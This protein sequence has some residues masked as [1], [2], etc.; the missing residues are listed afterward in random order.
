MPPLYQMAVW[1]SVSMAG[2]FRPKQSPFQPALFYRIEL[3]KGAQD[4]HAINNEQ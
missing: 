3:A 4:E 2:S 1:E